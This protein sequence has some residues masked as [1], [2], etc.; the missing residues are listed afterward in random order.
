[1][2]RSL[3]VR[4]YRLFAM[5]QVVS[6]TGTWMQRIAQDWLVLQLSGGSGMALGVTTALQF[7]PML[8][9]GLLGGTLV[10]RMNKRRLLVATQAAMGLLA[11]ALG[12]LATAG[13][14]QVWHVYLFAFGL[15]LVTVLDNPARQTF[16][17]EM[18][19]QRDLPNAIALN[20]ASFQLGRVTGPAVAGLLIA[21]FGSGP[22]FLV[23]ALSFVAVLTGLWL[24]RPAELHVTEPA[25]RAKGQTMEGLRYILG[26][27]D[28]VLLLVM[29]AFLQLFGANV[30]NQIALM[31]NNVF[32]AGADA[33]G[34]AAA[35]IAVGALA[36]ALLAAR[37][38][39]PRLGVLLAGA[40]A[41]GVLEIAAALTTGYLAFL[42]VLV[43]MGMAF[44]S[45]NTTM[46]AVFQTSVDPQ[47][48]GRVMSMF[49]LF[50]LGPAPIGAP[51]VGFLADRFGPQVSLATGGVVTVLV[52]VLVSVLLA[53]RRGVG[54]RVTPTRRPFLALT[55]R[56]LA[57][58]G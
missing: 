16:V 44:L 19:G 33:F 9:F 10:D 23:N 6:N 28:L 38:D 5:G 49:M 46:N 22:V 54:V 13:L 1:M 26:R 4:N 45:F 36:G 24:M 31:T 53:R 35:A 51:L 12:V 39:R 48:R 25:P 14:A 15:G 50:F 40:L 29:T 18:V 8:L 42:L 3:S 37:R 7:L 41:F 47:M 57:E 21:A 2:F 43:P 52:T 30:Q 58:T 27:R 32:R 17:V 11:L 20:S 34:V 56:P 55:R